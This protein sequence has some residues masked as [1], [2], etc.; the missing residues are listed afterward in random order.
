MPVNRCVL[1]WTLV[2]QS[3][4]SMAKVIKNII[5]VNYEHISCV[6]LNI[7]DSVLNSVCIY[8]LRN[9]MYDVVYY[10]VAI[11]LQLNSSHLPMLG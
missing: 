1:K 5:C 6:L 4:L 8:R 7:L 2:E 9:E 3:A 11:L 10:I